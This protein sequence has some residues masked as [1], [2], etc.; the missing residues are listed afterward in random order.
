MA[1]TKASSLDK[2]G[3]TSKNVTEKI[4]K[5]YS[6]KRSVPSLDKSG[7]ASKTEPERTEKQD[8]GKIR[9]IILCKR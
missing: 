5:L 1:K 7:S 2:S 4:E 8:S 6:K 9:K 3:S